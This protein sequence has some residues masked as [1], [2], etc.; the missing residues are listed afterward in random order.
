MKILMV[1]AFLVFLPFIGFGQY[2]KSWD[3]HEVVRFYEKIDL[4]S[5]TIDNEGEEIEEI[6][7]PT[8]IKDDI[9]EV[10]VY[11]L[12]SKLYKIQG[13]NIYMYFRYPPYM[14]SYDNGIVVVSYNSGTFYKKP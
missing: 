8:K 13:T 3:N 1:F 2:Y 10:E 6:Y 9:Y 4:D 12:S 7:I 5:Y 11:K 14:Y